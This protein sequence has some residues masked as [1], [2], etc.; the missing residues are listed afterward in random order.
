MLFCKKWNI[1]RLGEYSNMAKKDKMSLIS[2]QTPTCREHIREVQWGDIW[3]WQ[4]SH[5]FRE[6]LHINSQHSKMAKSQSNCY[7]SKG[8]TSSTQVWAGL[9]HQPEASRAIWREGMSKAIEEPGR[10]KIS[11]KTQV[12]D[13]LAKQDGDLITICR[14]KKDTNTKKAVEEC[15]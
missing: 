14:N 1:K 13:R 9:E 2:L 11:V 5:R 7:M 10:I 6:G 8:I 12:L 4:H 3:R 15:N